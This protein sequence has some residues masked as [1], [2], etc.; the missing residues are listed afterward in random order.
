RAL[1]FGD[2][3][4]TMSDGGPRMH[5]APGARGPPKEKLNP[6]MINTF[7]SGESSVTPNWGDTV[8]KVLR[9]GRTLTLGPMRNSYAG[10][11]RESASVTPSKRAS[12]PTLRV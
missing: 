8:T 7:A 3:G 1:V 10:S 11:L 5:F 9:V 2:C 12:T 6:A 4:G